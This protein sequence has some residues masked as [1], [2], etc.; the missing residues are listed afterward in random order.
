[1]ALII[2]SVV[3]FLAG[4]ADRMRGSGGVF[5]TRLG[6]SGEI[7]GAILTGFLLY[8]LFPMPAW[9]ILAFAVAWKLGEALG[10]SDIVGA[11]VRGEL[12]MKEENLERWMVGPLKN[13]WVASFTRGAIWGLP[14]AIATYFLIPGFEL[15]MF[16][17]Y[18]VSFPLSSLL[19]MR[20]MTGAEAWG[21]VEWVRGWI[22]FALLIFFMH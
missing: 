10:W 16:A 3:V 2:T 22:T 6:N 11:P 19:V 12:V 15:Y 5:P 21:W 18:V 1:M 9:G 4:F 7:P 17:A 20:V 13:W 14:M 8:F